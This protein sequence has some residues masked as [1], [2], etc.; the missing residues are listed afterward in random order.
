MALVRPVA[1]GAAG[2]LGWGGP[3]RVTVMSFRGGGG[4]LSVVQGAVDQLGYLGGAG[5]EVPGGGLDRRVAEE[6]L[7][8]GGVGAVLSEPGGV[9]VSEPVGAQAGQAGVGADRADHVG[10]PVDRQHAA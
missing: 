7:D 2:G 9:G 1:S 4:G 8:L 10:Q 5:P 3:V 6:V